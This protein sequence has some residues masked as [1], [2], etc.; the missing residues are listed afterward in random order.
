MS[1]LGDDQMLSRLV[2]LIPLQRDDLSDAERLDCLV[3]MLMIFA[4]EQ[5]W[6]YLAMLCAIDL[7]RED[8]STPPVGAM[9]K[10]DICQLLVM[11]NRIN[12]ALHLHL[13][14]PVSPI[15][16]LVEPRMP[17]RLWN[18]RKT[19]YWVT[20]ADIRAVFED[21]RDFALRLPPQ[22]R[23][24]WLR[25][26][27]KKR[28]R[29]LNNRLKD[30]A[31][32]Q[33]TRHHAALSW[34]YWKRLSGM[35]SDDAIHV[36]VSYSTGFLVTAVRAGK[37]VARKTHFLASIGHNLLSEAE[38]PFSDSHIAIRSVSGLVYR[39]LLALRSGDAIVTQLVLRDFYELL[40]RPVLDRPDIA[41]ELA[42]NPSRRTL[43]VTT[44]GALAQ[45]PFSALFDGNQYLAERFDVV[46]G[47]PLPSTDPFAEGDMDVE[48]VLGGEPGFPRKLRVL[49]DTGALGNLAAARSELESY[50]GLT[51]NGAM[52][53]DIVDGSAAWDA[54]T[55]DWLV[56]G[57][58]VALLSAHVQ[59]DRAGATGVAVRTPAGD[60]IPFAAAM[61][62][63]AAAD[64]AI[65]SGCHSYGQS[66]WLTQ[67][68]SMVALL[69]RHGVQATVATLWPINDL[70]AGIYNRA[71]VA[72]MAAGLSR[73]EAHGDAQRAVM[74]TR[75]SRSQLEGERGVAFASRAETLEPNNEV[76]LDHPYFWAPFM[77]SGAWR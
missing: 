36:R 32:M 60:A 1:R 16:S 12:E 63:H 22:H 9:A 69:R 50:A 66:D 68:D 7:L 23:S 58:G 47:G 8:R 42:A 17:A 76:S 40:L 73:A 28:F 31:L 62:Q 30:A 49:A 75:T 21:L 48:A 61:P 20:T 19:D 2:M 37:R 74:R 38:R 53:V 57:R 4:F 25:R 43:V 35:S 5:S 39:L 67:E 64:L 18:F 26:V 52:E 34:P 59:S 71:L 46:Q 77:L 3:E 41:A 10:E 56:S 54:S 6:H 33:L 24:P 55:L 45:L 15:G 13:N 14:E 27:L 44:H 70:A 65:L 51:A 29:K 72:G 11:N